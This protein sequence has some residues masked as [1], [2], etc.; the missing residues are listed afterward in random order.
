MGAALVGRSVS[1]D[2]GLVKQID[3]Y[4]TTAGID[5]ILLP[6][7]FASFYNARDTGMT[8]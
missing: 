5:W 3:S 8:L 6:D 2:L 4:S 1:T 7:F